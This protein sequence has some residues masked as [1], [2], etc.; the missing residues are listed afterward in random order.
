VKIAFLS[1]LDLNL[2]LFRLDIMRE[3][4]KRGDKVYAIIPKG[5]YFDLIAQEG[6]E[7]IDYNLSRGSLNPFDALSSIGELKNILEPL[8]LD[9][10][11]TFTVK[12]NIFGTFAG[13][14]AKVPKIYNLVEGLGSFYVDNSLKSRVVRFVIELL[15][16][17]S[18][19]FADMVVFVNSDD[20]KYLIKNRI[21]SESKV[22]IIKSVGIDTEEYRDD[23]ISD[24]VKNRLRDELAISQD[25]K[26][27]IM[28]A[29]AIL[30]KGT[31][32]FYKSAEILKD[33]GYRFLFVGGLDSG[34]KFGMSREFMEGGNVQWLDWRDDIKELISISHLVVLP[35]YREGVPRTLLEACSMGRP[36]VA[37]DVVGCRETVDDGENGY[38][39]PIE[40]PDILASKI[41]NILEDEELY[42]SMAQKSREKAVKEFDI[43][44]IVKQYME[45]YS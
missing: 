10:L 25:E 12:P 5:K 32:D 39:V 45:I 19:K 36:I 6:I 2:Y 34:N 23:V 1:S 29:R 35:S 20:P 33:R 24:E 3:L 11:H 37:T 44:N 15:Y 41:E 28:I 18:F 16:K 43:R 40:S 14:M 8:D 38:L 21:I 17:Q 42:K 4:Q 27:V 22:K 9:L 30:H 31:I 7:T 26:V 13:K